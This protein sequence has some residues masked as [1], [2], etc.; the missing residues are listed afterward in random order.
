VQLAESDRGAHDPMTKHGDAPAARAGDLHDE[1]VD[2]EAMEEAADLSTL[3]SRV[4]AEMASERGAEVAVREAVHSVLPCA[5][6]KPLQRDLA[7]AG[8]PIE[9]R[10]PG[11]RPSKARG[12]NP[13]ISGPLSQGEAFRIGSENV[14]AEAL[15]SAHTMQ[16]RLTVSTHDRLVSGQMVAVRR[17]AAIADGQAASSGEG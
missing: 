5:G 17:Q 6:Q 1:P 7:V 11:E 14:R 8:W 13:R 10:R 2:V 15:H 16:R 4:I 9:L 12:S 3:L